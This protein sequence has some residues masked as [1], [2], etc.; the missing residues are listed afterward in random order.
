M[1]AEPTSTVDAER[2]A[3]VQSYISPA[4]DFLLLAALTTTVA[5]ACA[6]IILP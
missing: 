6:A 1:A 3:D 4:A 5:V 2:E